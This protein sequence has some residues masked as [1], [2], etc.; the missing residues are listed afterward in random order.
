M[1]PP[2]IGV[3]E[4]EWEGDAIKLASTPLIEIF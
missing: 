3:R 2:D 1:C 4:F